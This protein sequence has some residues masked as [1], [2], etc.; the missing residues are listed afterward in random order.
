M[1]SCEIIRSRRAELFQR[2]TGLTEIEIDI[3]SRVETDCTAV[4]LSRRK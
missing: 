4:N 3:A 1:K 2:A